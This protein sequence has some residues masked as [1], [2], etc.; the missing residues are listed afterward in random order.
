MGQN[1]KHTD[2]DRGSSRALSLK[3]GD[4]IGGI[5]GAAVAL[6]QSMGLGIVLFTIMGFSTSAGALAGMVGATIL[7][8]ISG[9]VGATKAMIS[10]PNG[11]MTM[12]LAG[13]M[14]SLAAQGSSSEAMLLNLSA[15]LVSMGIFQ[16]LFS[17]MGGA[18]LI[19]YIPYPVVAGLVTGVG[20]LMVKSQVSMLSHDWQESF[21][22]TL[23]TSFP[24]IIA[25]LTMVAMYIVPKWSQKKI[26]GAVGG[27]ALGITLFY[28][29]TPLLSVHMETPWVVGQIPSLSKLHFGI[30]LKE[31]QSLSPQLIITTAL[32][33]TILGTT[34]SL[35]TS[36]VADSHTGAHHDSRREMIAQGAAE[37]VIGLFGALG[38]WGTKG[39]TL[40]TIEAGGGRFAPIVSG[41][42][43]LALMLF[44]GSIGTYL[45]V[46]VLAG[47]VAMVG[48]GM[49][50]LNILSWMRY[51][52]TRLDALIALTVVT[53]IISVN[54]VAAV[55]VGVLFSILLFISMQ[56][57]IPIVH[58]KVNA[59]EHHSVLQRT[60][61]ERSILDRYGEMIMLYELKGNLFFAT[62]D[63]LRME[64]EKEL[65]QEKQ[66]ILHFRRVG[67]IDMSAMIVLLQL[68]EDARK[69]G[70]ELIFCHLHKGLGFGKE[71]SKAF[72]HIDQKRTFDYRVFADG[73]TAFE[74]CEEQLLLKHGLST[75]DDERETPIAENDLCV[76]ISEA[77]AER[78][79]AIGKKRTLP[80]Q[81]VLFSKEDYGD[82]LFMVLKGSIE[83]RLT[84]GKR[85]YKRLAKYRKG[86]FFGEVSL[87]DPGP[88]AASAVVVDE[89][90]IAEFSRDA[91]AS[92][93]R[94]LLAVILSRIAVRLSEELRRS[95]ASIERL[96]K[97]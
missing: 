5:S 94:D 19:K 79:T 14:G 86:T 55:G 72:K 97:W 34:D 30:T 63:K 20:L 43:F 77:Y 25:L 62:A 67:Y 70:S 41:L 27:L 22:S 31:I 12:M 64:V 57:K 35:V 15:I 45:P 44:A 3:I 84:I 82:S 24:A 18:K 47:I 26:P 50:D 52:K 78:M 42:F 90:V 38:G 29:L 88:R 1:I 66:V 61:E 23:Q 46:S 58:R 85:Q 80:P 95:A 69:R 91:L 60:E 68:G 65:T 51:R 93:D 48:V 28:L 37:M 81:T 13:V 83:I 11:P 36:L 76:G 9:G 16:I 7:L 74:Y 59:K 39:A 10:A 32:A 33:L 75:S 56:I 6:P 4:V 96:E 53:V 89:C 49:I 8:F 40:V 17:L 87:I 2:T 54:L 92:V 73:D 21:P 71:V